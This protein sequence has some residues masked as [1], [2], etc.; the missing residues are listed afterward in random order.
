MATAANPKVGQQKEK[1][2]DSIVERVS[3]CDMS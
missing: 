2:F 1:D 3:Y